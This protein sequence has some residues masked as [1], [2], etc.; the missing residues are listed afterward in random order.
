[1]LLRWWIAGCCVDGVDPD[2]RRCWPVGLGLAAAREGLDDDQY[3][4]TARAWGL[5][6]RGWSSAA[7][8]VSGR[9]T[10]G[11]TASSSRARTMLSARLPLASRPCVG[12]V[13]EALRQHVDQETPD[14]HVGRQRHGLVAGR[15]G[16]VRFNPRS[17][18]SASSALTTRAWL[19]Q[20]DH[21]PAAAPGGHTCASPHRSASG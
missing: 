8:G 18:N 11:G 16:D 15:P 3:K 1:M 19:G 6:H 5:Q 2:R 17:T 12:C 14:E 13:M 7:L 10:G 4:S 20:P 9:F 21:R